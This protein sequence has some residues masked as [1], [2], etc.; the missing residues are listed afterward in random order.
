MAGM[1]L[2]SLKIHLFMQ[3]RYFL[4]FLCTAFAC[5]GAPAQHWIA[6]WAASAAPDLPTDPER[7]KAHLNLENQTLREVV[8]TSLGGSGLRIRLSNEFGLDTVVIGAV[9]VAACDAANVVAGFDRMVTFSGRSNFSIPPNA[10]FLSDPVDLNV[11]PASDLCISI[12]VPKKTLAAGVH[13]DA[14]QK[15]FIAP[16]DLTAAATLPNTATTVDSWFF[17]AG[18]DVAADAAAV[19]IVAFG[20]SITDGY[21][22]T[23][24]ANH[25]WPNYLADRLLA[26]NRDFAVIDSGIS[27]NSI[28]HDAEKPVSFG[29]NAL[30]RFEHDALG[31]PG[32]KYVIVLEGINDLAHPGASAPLSEKVS[33]DDL[34]AGLKQMIDRAH[35]HQIKII[36]ATLTP[37]EGA[38]C[39][40]CWSPEK[41]KE[42]QLL[43]EWIRTSGAFDGVIDFDKATQSAT[44]PLRMR[45]EFNSGDYVHPN[46]AGYKAMADAIDLS[47]FK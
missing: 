7:A 10:P 32:A 4:V 9:H 6:T 30:S 33:A 21:Q 36:G 19:T 13:Y 29:V 28:L 8:H 1:I 11:A 35:E 37:V 46:D 44:D 31:E 14:Q 34:I 15:N 20:D 47:L 17:V 5:V 42:R 38:T 12:F 23:V 22:S 26:A 18:V 25:R 3:I 40:G 45:E 39:T 43:N 2:L 16:G 41:E 24:N 27:G